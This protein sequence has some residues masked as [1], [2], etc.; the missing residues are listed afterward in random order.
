MQSLRLSKWLARHSFPV[1]VLGAVLLLQWAAPPGL[2]RSLQRLEGLLYDAKVEYLPPWPR[3][4]SNIQIVDIDEA[5]LH[6]IGRMPWDR[7]QFVRLTEKLAASGAVLVV[8]DVLFAEPQSNAALAALQGWPQLQALPDPQRHEL[9]AYLSGLDPDVQFA[10][11]IRTVDVVL[12]TLL[13]RE[14]SLH[15]GQLSP[16]GPLQVVQRRPAGQDPFPS[17]SGY[18]GPVPVLATAARGLG[19]INAEADAD[20]FVRRVALLHQYGQQLYPSLALEAFRVYSLLDQ[21]EPLWLQQAEQA[22]LQGIKLG[23]SQ[24]RTDQ[25]GRILVPYRGGARHY[26]YSSAADVLRDRI[27]DQRFDQAVVFVGT[28]ATGLADL[29]ATPTSLTFP[30]VEI[31]ATVFDGLMAPQNLPYRPDWS[32]GA[33][34]IQLL[35]LGV[36]C[37]WLFPRLGPLGSVAAGVLLLLLVSSLNLWLWRVQMLDL[38]LLPQ[39]LL[40]VL[41]PLYFI[42]YGFINENRRRQQINHIFGQYLPAA[43]IQRLLNDP[44]AASLSGEKKQLSVLFCDIRSFTTIAETMSAQALKLWLNQYFNALTQAIQT[45]GGTID[46][47]VGDMVMAFWGAPLAEPAHACK[48]IRAAFAMQKALQALNQ[49]YADTGQPQVRI[50][51][52]INSGEMN[53]GDMG[54]DFRRN[55]TVIGDAVNLGAR[56]ESL[57]KFYGLPVLVSESTKMLAP[58]FDYVLVDKVR[59]KGKQIPVQIYLPVAADASAAQRHWYQAFSSALTCYFAADVVAAGQQFRQFSAEYQAVPGEPDLAALIAQYQQRISVWQQQPPAADWDG[60]YRHA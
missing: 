59:V 6:Q 42:S 44:A 2:D 11:A 12:A 43:H 38:P 20:G 7:Q 41:L 27:K 1:C 9:Q 21:I 56:L 10:T 5:S 23:N 19:F 22:V 24:V 14:G 52:G 28:S 58:D 16:N 8:Y 26:P 47:Y 36:G 31:H 34:F 51:I 13:H 18:A 25:Q 30:G 39:L 33:T 53:V 48:S 45:E 46:K 50:G 35:L 29:Q 40:V 60:S 37:L 3:S 4:V 32:D 55:Y 49:T 57:T 54:S 15:S 17:F